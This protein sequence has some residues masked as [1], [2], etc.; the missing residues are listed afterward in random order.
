MESVKFAKTGSRKSSAGGGH[1]DQRHKGITSIPA[2]GMGWTPSSCAPESETHQ[3]PRARESHRDITPAP[4][5]A[6]KFS[7]EPLASDLRSDA[8]V[9][10]TIDGM[11]ASAGHAKDQR[12]KGKENHCD[13]IPA[14]NANTLEYE[15]G[16][17]LANAQGPID[18]LGSS[19]WRR[20]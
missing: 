14:P 4:D 11:G 13:A 1:Q 18:Q 9:R 3:E 2:T 10:Q 20:R 5:A 15:G 17:A 12:A 19:A 16:R 8:V 7:S 6:E